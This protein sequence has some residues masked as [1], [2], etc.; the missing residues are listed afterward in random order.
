VATGVAQAQQQRE[1]TKQRLAADAARLQA[2]VRAELDW[3]GRLKRD[4]P[5]LIA[6]GAGALV[7]V[8]AIVVLRSRLRRHKEPEPASGATLE[9]LAAELR[10]IRKN[11]DKSGKPPL[12]QQALLRGITAAGAAGGTLAAKRLMEQQFSG[13]REEAVASGGH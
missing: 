13:G 7:L 10:E 12:W 6:L 11:I 3:R 5:R 1:L 4:G 2:R 9:E 8:G